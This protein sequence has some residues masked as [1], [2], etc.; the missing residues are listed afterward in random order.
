VMFC[1]VGVRSSKTVM[2]CL[3]IHFDTLSTSIEWTNSAIKIAVKILY[4]FRILV[5][6]DFNIWG[7]YR[8]T[9]QTQMIN[10]W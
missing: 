1:F 5:L 7:V 3:S 9:K 2:F 10:L 8:L 6:Q 4:A